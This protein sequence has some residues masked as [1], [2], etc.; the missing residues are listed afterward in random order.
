MSAPRILRRPRA[1]ADLIE[2][3]AFIAGDKA[4]PADR[5]LRVA[6]S[7]FQL[8]ARMPTIGTAWESPD[9]RLAGVRVYPLPRGFRNYRVFYRPLPDGVEVLAVLHG[10]R[11]LGAALEDVDVE[12]GPE[13]G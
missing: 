3:Y 11:D 10:A 4:A 13:Q 1:K 6:E 12:E 8:L 2:H 9:P 7:S 5:F